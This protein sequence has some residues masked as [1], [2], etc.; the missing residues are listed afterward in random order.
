MA[1]STVPDCQPAMGKK[2]NPKNEWKAAANKKSDDC[3]GM[4][5]DV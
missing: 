1:Q 2:K 5:N 3:A 4:F